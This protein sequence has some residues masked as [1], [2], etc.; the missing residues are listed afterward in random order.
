MDLDQ[1]TLSSHVFPM[2]LH[3]P[4]ARARESQRLWDALDHLVGP[5]VGHGEVSTSDFSWAS[6]LQQL[7]WEQLSNDGYVMIWWRFVKVAQL[8]SGITKYRETLP[9]VAKH[10]Q[11]TAAVVVVGRAPNSWG[12]AAR[13]AARAMPR[14]RTLTTKK[15]LWNASDIF[16]NLADLFSL[17]LITDSAGLLSTMVRSNS[18]YAIWMILPRPGRRRRDGTT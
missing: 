14:I 16:W 11:A 4:E 2:Q 18:Q 17:S 5:R 12:S 9:N 3:Y 13:S 15:A 7:F 6:Q 10:C 8:V 1:K